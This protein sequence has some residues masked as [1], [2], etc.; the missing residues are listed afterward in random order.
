MAL[1]EARF[2]D[3]ISGRAKDPAAAVLRPLLR[4]ASLPYGAAMAVRRMAYRR[5]WKQSCAA[6][7]PVISVGNITTGGTGKTPLVA[8]VVNVLKEQGRRPAVLIR[9]YKGQGG[10]SDEA[11]LLAGLTDSPIIVNPD[12]VAG[13]AA[14]R[15]GGA[16]VLVMDDGFQHCRLRRDLDIVTIDATCPFGYDAMLPRGL[17]RESTAA[18]AGADVLVLTRCDQAT[19]SD[20][21]SIRARLGELAPQ[22]LLAETAARPTMIAS[23]TGPVQPAETLA[24]R[25]AW[26]FCGLGNPESFYRTLEDL[27]LRL[28]GKTTFNDHHAYAAADLKQILEKADAAGSECVLTTA[29]DAVKLQGLDPQ[30]VG[31]IGWVHIELVFLAGQGPLEEHLRQMAGGSKN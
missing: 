11:A 23:M 26:A 31:R 29:K 10:Q 7:V 30:L 25:T 8:W 20:L 5:G 14:A 12:R 22:A 9:G 2:R 15:A 19:P 16:D 13:A 21:S 18:L 6:G 17:L 1:D 27:G 4:A 24:G 3:I 28:L